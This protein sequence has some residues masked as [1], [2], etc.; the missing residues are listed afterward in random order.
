MWAHKEN[1]DPTFKKSKFHMEQCCT[2]SSQNH[3][4][5]RQEYLS[6]EA[7]GVA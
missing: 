7:K 2:S 5:A 1:D 6:L 3:S 4:R